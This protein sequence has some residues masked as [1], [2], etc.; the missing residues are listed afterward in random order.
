MGSLTFFWVAVATFVVSTALLIVGFVA[1]LRAGLIGRDDAW[2]TPPAR[3]W[4]VSGFV[5]L[6]VTALLLAGFLFLP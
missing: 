6:G 1:A 4:F 5:M 3:R 2:K